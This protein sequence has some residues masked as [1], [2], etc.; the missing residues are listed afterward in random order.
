[1]LPRP[2]R[3]FVKCITFSILSFCTPLSRLSASFATHQPSKNNAKVS[4][5]LLLYHPRFDCVP[6]SKPTL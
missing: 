2:A 3:V 1:L 4:K 6:L 5:S